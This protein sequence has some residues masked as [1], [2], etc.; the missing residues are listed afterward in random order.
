MGPFRRRVVRAIFILLIVLAAAIRPA[1][2]GPPY[3]TDDPE[4]ADYR[5]FEI[6]LA[7]EYDHDS[8][9]IS[10]SLPLLDVNYGVRPNLQLTVSM[11]FAYE[12]SSDAPPAFGRGSTGLGLKYRFLQETGAAPQVAF[13][14]QIV[15]PGVKPLGGGRPQLFL[16]FWLQKSFGRWTAFGGG[17]RWINPGAG[18]LDYWVDGLAIV[19][20]LPKEASIGAEVYHSTPDSVGGESKTSVAVGFTTPIAKNRNLLLSIGRGVHGDNDFSGYLGY[21]L[22]LGP[23][24]E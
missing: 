22:R 21:E 23:N 16:P 17:G 9:E 15:F 12:H 5:H 20:A 19:R 7:T 6:Y 11:P 2:A 10:G 8:D 13:Y 1:A 3:Q 4:P 14:P 18:N 24:K